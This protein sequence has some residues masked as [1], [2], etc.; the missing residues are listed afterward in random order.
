MLAWL[1]LRLPF[2]RAVPGLPALFDA[3]L[4]GWTGLFH[5]RRLVALHRVEAAALAWPG[6]TVK[7]HRFGGTEFTLSTGRGRCEI[8]HLHGNGLLDIPFPP[9]LRDEVVRAGQARPHHIFPRSGWVSF[10]IRSEA[11]AP[12]AVALL[13]RSYDRR[14]PDVL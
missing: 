6:I 10:Y 2:L 4:M 14:Q 8:G 9:A 3:L 1:A 11:D 5:P 12:D 13:R 7:V